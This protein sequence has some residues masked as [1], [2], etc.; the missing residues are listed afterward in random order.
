[1]SE[2]TIKMETLLADLTVYFVS[3]YGMTPRD[4]VGLVM[5][6]D[7]AEEMRHPGSPLLEVPVDQ[8]AALLIANL[9]SRPIG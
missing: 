3:H 1:M 4:A 7:L 5:Q 8:L 9:K 6:S 2:A